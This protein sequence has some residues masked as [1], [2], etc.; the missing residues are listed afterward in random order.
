M[1]FRW[2]TGFGTQGVTAR[3][4]DAGSA[5][6]SSLKNLVPPP[7]SFSKG[8]LL[9]HSLATPSHPAMLWISPPAWRNSPVGLRLLLEP[10][11][12]LAPRAGVWICRYIE[13]ASG[14][15]SGTLVLPSSHVLPPTSTA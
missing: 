5:P 4:I 8:P 14:T 7:S 9:G 10:S 15:N 1:R 11:Q 6:V 13:N 12:R 2:S 3:R